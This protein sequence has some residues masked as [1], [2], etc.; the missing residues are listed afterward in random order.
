MR[1]ARFAIPA[2]GVAAVAALAVT[3][4]T[5]QAREAYEFKVD[6]A[7]QDIT[8]TAGEVSIEPRFRAIAD[9]RFPYEIYYN[10]HR[11]GSSTQDGK[12]FDAF[13][14]REN[15]TVLAM[16]E[17]AEDEQEGRSDLRLAVQYEQI[18]FLIDNGRGRYSGYVGPTVGTTSAKFQEILPDGTR[19]DVLNIPGMVGVNASAMEAAR[20][21][22]SLYGS[23][24]VFFSV[25]GQ[26]R[27]Y[28]D[29]YHADFNNNDQRN[30]PGQLVDPVH[31]ALGLNTQFAKEAK[32]KIGQTTEVTRRFAV[33]VTPGATADYRFVYKLEKLYGTVAEPTAAKFSFTATPVNAE[34]TQTIDG[35]TVR[36]AAPEIKD[37]MLV[38]DIAK[39]VAADVTWSLSLKG[40]A[41]QAGGLASEFS[42]D[43]DYRASLRRK[44]KTEG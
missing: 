5:A 36:F 23:G 11:R 32:L 13:T 44:P 31:L 16:L 12:P 22:Q 42:V 41:T 4:A 25:D 7:K 15:W 14:R 10:T 8:A 43:A 2:L 39:G 29:Q 26:G 6:L 9:D 33:G 27:L 1:F 38:Y 24:T 21:S 35:I 18:S 20:S 40:T 19:N 34:V 37:G 17:L 30:H 28:N 3:L